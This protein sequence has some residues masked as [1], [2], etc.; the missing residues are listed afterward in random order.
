MRLSSA[1]CHANSYP[2]SGYSEILSTN[3]RSDS[4]LFSTALHAL[5]NEYATST[6]VY[7]L[8]ETILQNLE[9]E[10]FW[11]INAQYILTT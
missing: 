10:E 11:M 9:S 5:R 6:G 8:V 3:L 2:K 7:K 1:N 4:D